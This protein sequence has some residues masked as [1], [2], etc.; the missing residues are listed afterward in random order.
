M[1]MNLRIPIISRDQVKVTTLMIFS[2]FSKE[3]HI[4]TK[5]SGFQKK[6]ISQNRENRKS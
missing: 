2:L 1:K 6:I 5:K 3:F 4:F